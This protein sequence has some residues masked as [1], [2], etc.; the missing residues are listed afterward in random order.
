MLS[1]N[2]ELEVQTL[3][4]KMTFIIFDK[5][6]WN[7]T[8]VPR[9]VYTNLWEAGTIEDPYFGR[10]SVKAQWVH[11]YEWWY[12]IQFPIKKDIANQVA[13]IVFEGVD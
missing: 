13:D 6:V 3:L 9:D 4:Y 1:Y 8:K 2:F 5:L 7:N 11:Y 10:N 12:I